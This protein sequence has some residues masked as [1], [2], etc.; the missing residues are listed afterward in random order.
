MTGARL[1]HVP[2]KGGTA[3]IAAMLAG[4]IQ[5]GMTS[6]PPLRP[7]LSSGRL[8]GLAIT[9][10]TRSPALPELPTVAE[11]GVPGFE[12]DQWYGVITGSRVPPAIVR[13]LNAGIAEALK[14]QDV[15]RRLSAD[16]ATPAG[17]APEQFSEYI[18][19]ERAKWGKL[20]KD[21]GLVLN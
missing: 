7:H 21:I 6:V 14:S 3:V 9:A 15:V 2:Y 1:V 13:K 8:R 17:S 19:S 20:A 12:V 5:L 4:D 16:G 18:R 10:K 11:A